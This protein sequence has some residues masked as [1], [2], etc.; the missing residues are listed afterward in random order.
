MVNSRHNAPR[1]IG[2]DSA[3]KLDVTNPIEQPDETWRKR[4]QAEETSKHTELENQEKK[5]VKPAFLCRMAT[6]QS[7]NG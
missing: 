4:V 1:N 2:T 5:P 3:N 7:A 6:N